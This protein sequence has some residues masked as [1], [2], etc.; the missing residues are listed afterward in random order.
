MSEVPRYHICQGQPLLLHLV[1]LATPA[2]VPSRHHQNL[3]KFL[4]VADCL[5]HRFLAWMTVDIAWF[6]LLSLACLDI[7]YC[8]SHAQ[9]IDA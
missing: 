9:S 6:T 7:S 2:F 5:G 1:Y 3:L 8:D 4:S